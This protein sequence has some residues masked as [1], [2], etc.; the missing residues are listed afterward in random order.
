[1]RGKLTDDIEARHP[2]LQGTIRDHITKQGRAFVRF[3]ASRSDLSL[4]AI[5]EPLPPSRCR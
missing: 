4:Q 3:F 5:A 2:M 1:M